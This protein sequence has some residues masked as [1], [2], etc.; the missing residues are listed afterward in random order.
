MIAK[1]TTPMAGQLQTINHVSLIYNPLAKATQRVL[2]QVLEALT[3]AKVSFDTLTLQDTDR[4][5]SALSTQLLIVLGG[6]GTLL[7]VTQWCAHNAQLTQMPPLVG[8]N[9]GHLGFLT[10][11]EAQRLGDYLPRLL[12]GAFS[13]ENRRL[14]AANL[15]NG[16]E[17]LLGVNDVVVKSA[18]PSQM[19]AF[20][21]IINDQMIAQTQADGMIIATPTGS[22]AYTLAAGGPI[23]SPDVDALVVTP[24]CPHSFTAKPIVISS[25]LSVCI[26]FTPKRP[27]SKMII[28]VDGQEAGV[29]NAHEQMTIQQA[30]QTLPLVTFDHEPAEGFFNLLHHKLQWATDPRSIPSEKFPK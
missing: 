19:A 17:A 9:T 10:R 7:R 15:P 23:V 21:L 5:A 30:S 29:L 3:C 25:R 12:E 26:E 27:D 14:L 24:I 22:T 28:S 16:S 8:I 11:I 6:D 1:D 4:L 20:N 2:P 18:N 13:V